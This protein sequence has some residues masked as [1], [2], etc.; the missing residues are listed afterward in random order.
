MGEKYGIN[1]E[2]RPFFSVSLFKT[3]FFNMVLQLGTFLSC[4]DVFIPI[5]SSAIY[6]NENGLCNSP[7]S[8]SFVSTIHHNRNSFSSFLDS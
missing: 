2:I 4:I 3:V 7:I 6:P 1:Y 5:S 8:S